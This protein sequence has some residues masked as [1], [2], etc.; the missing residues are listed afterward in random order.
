[1]VFVISFAFYCLGL[2]LIVFGGNPRNQRLCKSV[3][4]KAAD[5]DNLWH[6]ID[7]VAVGKRCL[8][9]HLHDIATI[10]STRS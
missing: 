9:G 10:A 3:A 5:P 2:L 6:R 4:R 7:R 1:V 8:E